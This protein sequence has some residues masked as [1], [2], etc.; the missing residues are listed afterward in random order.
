MM[1]YNKRTFTKD[2]H[3]WGKCVVKYLFD[4]YTHLTNILV[5]FLIQVPDL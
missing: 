3:Q 5:T 2:A 4:V 1:L